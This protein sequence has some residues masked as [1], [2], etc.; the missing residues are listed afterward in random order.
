MKGSGEEEL[1]RSLHTWQY[2]RLHLPF[3]QLHAV[4]G[5]AGLWT[6]TDTLQP[7]GETVV[8]LSKTDRCH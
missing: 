5:L 8:A 7:C 3:Q 4:T 1:G 6:L 2:F